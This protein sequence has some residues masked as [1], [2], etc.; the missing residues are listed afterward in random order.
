MHPQAWL[1]NKHVL[2][3][4]KQRGILLENL[5]HDVQACLQLFPLCFPPKQT[6]RATL[7]CCGHLLTVLVV[8]GCYWT[9]GLYRSR[10]WIRLWSDHVTGGGAMELYGALT[11]A[12]SRSFFPPVGQST[13]CL[14]VDRVTARATWLKSLD[15]AMKGFR[16]YVCSLT[17]TVWCQSQA[18]RW[19][20]EKRKQPGLTASSSMS[21]LNIW[22]TVICPGLQHL[23]LPLSMQFLS[24]RIVWK[25]ST[26]TLESEMSLCSHVSVKH[27]TLLHKTLSDSL[28][29]LLALPSC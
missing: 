13:D 9:R 6:W 10:R 7:V 11:M 25:P 14:K 12:Y 23:L 15:I 3:K 20:R 1:V 18:P 8:T 5:H 29:G 27:K 22:L 21:G 26:D 4:G 28:P 16:C 17:I 2:G 19:P 24:A